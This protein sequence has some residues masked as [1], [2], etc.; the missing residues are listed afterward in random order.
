MGKSAA[1]RAIEAAGFV[2]L[3][4]RRLPTD[5]GKTYLLAGRIHVNVYDTG[6]VTIGGRPTDAQRQLLA[7]ALGLSRR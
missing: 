3:E 5:L 4:R 7:C 1:R 6:T 2:I